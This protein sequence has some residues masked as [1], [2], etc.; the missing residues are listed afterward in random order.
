VT[1]SQNHPINCGETDSEFAFNFAKQTIDERSVDVS[2]ITEFKPLFVE[3]LAP[4]VLGD[5]NYLRNTPAIAG[6]NAR[7]DLKY[8]QNKFSRVRLTTTSNPAVLAPV[9]GDP[10]LF[11]YQSTGSAVLHL[12]LFNGERFAKLVNAT[13]ESNAIVDTFVSFL[14]GS[15]GQ[16]IE[17]QTRARANGSTS[18]PNHYPIYSTFSPAT[19]TYTKNTGCWAS[20]LDFSGMM[21][22]KVGSGGVTR[23]SAI[24]PHHAIGAAHYGPEVGD[25]IVFCDANNQTVSRTV[26]ARQDISNFDSCIV[27]F[28]EALPGTVKTYKTLPSNWLNYAP[29]NTTRG[30]RSYKWPIITTSHYRWDAGWPLQRF[31]RFAYINEVTGIGQVIGFVPDIGGGFLDY[32]GSPS[33]IR[34]GDSGGPCFFIIN[35]DLVLVHCFFGANGGPFIPSFRGQIQTALDTL[36]PGGQTFET[37]NLSGF[38]NFAN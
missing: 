15:L 21:V 34:G 29:I 18:S 12:E 17:A 32:N 10:L 4:A 38:T 30:A 5:I 8:R 23:V 35:G 36:G 31:N 13:T 9:S 37:V 16:H 7:L 26:S 1:D 14:P 19:N 2:V 24:T 25:V 27:R 11:E 20:D 22:N 28:S 6:T 33:G 3:T